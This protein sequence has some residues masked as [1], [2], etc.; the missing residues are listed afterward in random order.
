MKG[1]HRFEGLEL[2]ENPEEQIKNY[3]KKFILGLFVFFVFILLLWLFVWLT[4]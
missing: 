3:L 4:N 2:K 1:Y